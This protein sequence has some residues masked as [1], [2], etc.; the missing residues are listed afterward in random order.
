VVDPPEVEP[1]LP[2]LRD[3]ESPP[4][5]A[6]VPEPV[7]ELAEVEGDDDEVSPLVPDESCFVS[8]FVEL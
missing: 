5:A 6:G 1:P 4:P 7:D 3:D 8:F 2:P